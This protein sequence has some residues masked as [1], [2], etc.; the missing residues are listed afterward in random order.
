MFYLL[1][2]KNKIRKLHLEVIRLNKIRMIILNKVNKR[3]FHKTQEM[4]N[5]LNKVSQMYLKKQLKD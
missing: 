4:Q 3:L 1:F 5:L 2:Q